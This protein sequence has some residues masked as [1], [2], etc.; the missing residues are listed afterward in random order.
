MYF[1]LLTSFQTLH[2]K[3][4]HTVFSNWTIALKEHINIEVKEQVYNT[5]SC[6]LVNTY[7]VLV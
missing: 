5:Y 7:M 3:I 4:Q 6:L 1:V 2:S